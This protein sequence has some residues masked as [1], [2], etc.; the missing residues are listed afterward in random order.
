VGREFQFDLTG[1]HPALDLA[2]TVSRRDDPERRAE[3][4]NN[5]CDLIALAAQ[6][7]MIS[8]SLARQIRNYAEEHPGEAARSF[9]RTRELREA[10]YRAYAAIAKG[11][12]AAD[13]DVRAI[14]RAANEALRHRRLAR[15]NGSYR[16]EWQAKSNDLDRL[17]W[18]IALAA[19]ELLASDELKLVRW[20][21]APDCEWLFLDNS[22]NRSR[23]WCDMK[24]CGNRAKARRHY[25]RA[26]T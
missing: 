1:G 10:I 9:R 14:E 12:P 17:L 3:H 22:R 26:R 24:S 8:S 16:W 4:L 7:K 5:Y 15:K 19:A 20:C 6:S 23:R 18:P 2:N 13:D 25:Q 11:K 21:E